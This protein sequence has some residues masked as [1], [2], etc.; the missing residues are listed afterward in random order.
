M[1]IPLVNSNSVNDINTSLI[2]VRKEINSSTGATDVNINVNYPENA[3]PV[4]EVTSG[5][6]HSVTSNAVAEALG[7][8]ETV[9]TDNSTYI[10]RGI[11]T[12]TGTYLQGH[13]QGGNN[14]SIIL[15]PKYRP[16]LVTRFFYFETNGASGDRVWFA[17]INDDGT[18]SF[19]SGIIYT[20]FLVR[21]EKDI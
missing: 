14:V 10:I 6:M 12:L 11:E 1:S 13:F 2:A 20:D 7:E 4:D 15:P 3:I 5:N 19:P 9:A 17:N 16:K 21:I 18:I 8:W